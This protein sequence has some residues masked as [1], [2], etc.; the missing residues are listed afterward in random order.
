MSNTEKLKTAG[1]NA[2]GTSRL[3]VTKKK[4]S[5]SRWIVPAIIGGAALFAG[6][7][8]MGAS[9]GQGFLSSLFGAGKKAAGTVGSSIGS[10]FSGGSSSLAIALPAIN[11]LVDKGNL[12]KQQQKL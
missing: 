4:K 9:S 1:L 3:S 2:D 8:G 6:I 12:G 7:G 10:F 5:K 11:P